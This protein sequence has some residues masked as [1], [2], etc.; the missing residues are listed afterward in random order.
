MHTFQQPNMFSLKSGLLSL[1][2]MCLNVICN[3]ERWW[4][5]ILKYFLS[6]INVLAV[7]PY[8]GS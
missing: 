2:E 6:V 3:S 8:H 1:H 7:L 4:D 5:K